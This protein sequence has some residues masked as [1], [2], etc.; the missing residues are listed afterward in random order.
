Y[1]A[2]VRRYH[3]LHPVRGYPRP[4]DYSPRGDDGAADADDVQ[5]FRR[6]VERYE[7]CRSALR[8]A[9]QTDWRVSQV[10]DNVVLAGWEMPHQLGS[11]RLGLNALAHHLRIGEREEDVDTP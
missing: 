8:E 6:A 3:S 2:I 10:V 11:L 9:D 4:G 5:A 1:R 7:G